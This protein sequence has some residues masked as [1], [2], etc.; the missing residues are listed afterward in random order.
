MR[1]KWRKIIWAILALQLLLLHVTFLERN[2]RLD[3]LIGRAVGHF[4]LPF[5]LYQRWR[6]LAA[7]GWMGT[8]GL[9]LLLHYGNY[10]RFRSLC[11][12]K[13]RAVSD[14]GTRQ[15]LEEAVRETGL[16]REW[17]AGRERTILYQCPGI[18]EPFVIGFLHPIL[19]LPDRPYSRQVLKFIF[20][21]EC[22][23]IRH[24]D[25]LYKLFLLLLQSLLWF[26]PLMYLLK[27][28]GDRDVEVA[29]DE[30]VVAGRSQEERRE[31]G[32]ALLDC[33]RQAR[34]KGAAYSAFFYHGKRLMQARISAIMEKDKKWDVLAYAG[35]AVLLLD[36]G[37]NCYRVGADWYL[38]YQE[39]ARVEEPAVPIYEGYDVPDSFTRSA[40]EAMMHLTPVSEDAYY[41]EF[42]AGDLYEE[43]E[44]DQLPYAAEG[45]WQIRLK[46]ADRYNE[47]VGLLLQRYL[48]YY[49]DWE[50]ATERSAEDR[51]SFLRIDTVHERLLAGD[52]KEAVFGVIFRYYLGTQLEMEQFPEELAAKARFAYEGGAYYAYF[53]WTVR[54]R[55][56]QDYVF[57]LEGIAQTQAVT[58]A[59]L[60]RYEEADFSDVPVLDLV[61]EVSGPKWGKA[62]SG[63]GGPS[64][65]GLP[66][67]DW[68]RPQG[69]A[70][71]P[72]SG[73]EGAGAE[74]EAADGEFESGQN[75]DQEAYRLE[76]D[77]AE[78]VVRIS[79][80]DGVL[81]E[82]PV[83][84]EE[85][86]ERGDQMDGILTSL[87]RESYQVDE[88]KQIIA[89]GGS[90]AVPFRVVY[91]EEETESFQT[92]VVTAKYIGGRRIFVNFPE[93]GQDG[94]LILTGERVVWQE[95]TILFRTRD[96]GRTWQEVGAAGPDF[97]REGHSLTTGA[98]FL[99]NRVGFVTIRD[100]EVPDVW[101]TQDGGLTWERQEIPGPPEHYSMAYAPEYRDGVLCLYVGMEDYSEYGGKKAKYESADEGRTW[102]YRGLVI[103]K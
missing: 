66:P 50:W 62:L 87:P 79:G 82:V 81:R 25:T 61:Y 1:A 10:R 84:L 60:E 80:G 9:C 51:A 8:A 14:E 96:G 77:A 23:H 32:N 33:A 21:H 86:L 7:L 85:L 63:E 54:I 34:E 76:T 42:W 30:A 16:R 65:E 36:L 46:D 89:Y 19:V 40:I 48:C 59:F 99:N 57:E 97:N 68:D 17:T 73:M 27:A 18:R 88:R 3:F 49:T 56:V 12:H 98:V 45:P 28:L 24:R 5:F 70:P 53:D 35:I 13:I 94:F 15:L 47:A 64:E 26:Q 2:E 93:N 78:G 6:L 52:K 11:I 101:R 41:E 74:K 20:L 67:A 55:M 39:S 72:G 90:G 69:G 83:P 103:R 75:R 37:Y 22:C 29:C 91:Y 58:E 4:G 38:R 44:Y 95:S 43:K 102:E 92:S 71:V 31:Y 100:S